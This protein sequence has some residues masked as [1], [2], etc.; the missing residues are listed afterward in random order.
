MNTTTRVIIAESLRR[1][2][3][4]TFQITKRGILI[5]S[6]VIA[7]L[8]SAFGV[9]YVKDLNR[10]LFIQ[11]QILRR[12]KAEEL[13]Q[14]GKLLLEQSTWS[15]Q[16]R[17]QKVGQKQLGMQIPTAKEMVLVNGYDEMSPPR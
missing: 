6:L 14:W 11:Y 3:S 9:I 16:S 2:R 8:C 10:R 7:L 15:T 13:I 1:R 17:I 4:R 5:V 12:E